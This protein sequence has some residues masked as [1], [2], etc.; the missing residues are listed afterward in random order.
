MSIRSSVVAFFTTSSLLSGGSPRIHPSLGRLIG[1]VAHYLGK[2]PFLSLSGQ[3]FIDAI[4]SQR[5]RLAHVLDALSVASIFRSFSHHDPSGR[6]TERLFSCL[7]KQ[8]PRVVAEAPSIWIVAHLVRAVGSVGGG[9][10]GAEMR[11]RLLD[12]IGKLK[13]ILFRKFG[14]KAVRE[15]INGNF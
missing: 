7:S 2:G 12:E 5:E 13:S 3:D 8:F 1:D 14:D 9:W 11:G 10:D 15:V 4:S 6:E